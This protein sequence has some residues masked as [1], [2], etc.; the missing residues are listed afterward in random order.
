MTLYPHLLNRISIAL[1]TLFL[2]CLVL[3]L[4]DPIWLLAPIL[5]AGAILSVQ[6]Y[7]M[8][9]SCSPF[10]LVIRGMIVTRTI[11]RS[12]ITSITGDSHTI[13]LAKWRDKRGKDRWSPIFV[14]VTKAREPSFTRRTKI[15]QLEKIQ[16]WF[17]AEP[18]AGTGSDPS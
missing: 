14:F 13:P 12:A 8:S 2:G 7:R 16:A 5:F 17:R 6:C 18:A 10:V 9:V 3:L 1:S 15:A 4:V 11:P